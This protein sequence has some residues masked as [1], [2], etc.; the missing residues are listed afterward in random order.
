MKE[1]KSYD[2]E[3]IDLVALFKGKLPAEVLRKIGEVISAGEPALGLEIL[4]DKLFDAH[5]PIPAETYSQIE[6][7]GE[8]MGMSPNLWEFLKKSAAN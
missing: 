6:R 3:L 5:V 4:C 1:Y 2:E 7:L 8:T